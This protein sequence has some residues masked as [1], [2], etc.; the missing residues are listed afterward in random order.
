VV[1]HA[2][3]FGTDRQSA[4]ARS[5][6]DILIRVELKLLHPWDVAPSEA[7]SIQRRLAPMVMREGRP[8]NVRLIAGTDISVGG[9]APGGAPG[10]AAVVVLTWPDLEPVEQ[11]VVEAQ[12]A[13]PYVPGLLSFREIPVLAPALRALRNVPDLLVVD[14]QGIAHPRRLGL[15]AHLGLLLDLPAIGCAKS[16]LIGRPAGDLDSARGA[17]VPL[18]DRGE[19]VGVVLRTR[20][21]TNPVYVSTGHQVSL[22]VAAEWVLAL[23][24]RFRL[25]EPTR[26]AHQAAAGKQVA[27]TADD[28]AGQREH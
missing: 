23:A 19:T 12:V 3:A 17:S 8:E 20:K 28:G 6:A 9:E 16:R 5:S 2:T 10:R 22:D 7:I 11:S 27:P 21:D 24:P 18:V 15:A 1:L 25:P 4:W 26:L 13:F 14:G